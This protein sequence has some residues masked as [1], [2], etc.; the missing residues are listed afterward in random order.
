MSIISNLFWNYIATKVGSQVIYRQGINLQT[1]ETNGVTGDPA[2]IATVYTCCKVLSDNLSRMPLSV[3]LEN[4]NGRQEMKRHRL[5]YLLKHRPNNYQNAQVFWSTVEYHRNYYGNAFVR[6]YKNSNAFPTALEIIHPQL[7]KQYDFLNGELFYI[8]TNPKNNTELTVSAWDM[9]HFGNISEDG[10]ISLSPL[11]AI[12]RQTNINE[13]ATKTLD[14][15]HEN[16]AVTPAVL[17]SELP[18][19]LSGPSAGALKAS[20]ENFQEAYSGPENAGKW[21]QLPLGYKYK[22][23]AMQFADAQLIE[24][25]RFTREDISAA[26]GIPLF[27]VDGSA[28]KLDVEQLTTLFKNNTM[29]PIVARYM[30]EIN[31]KLLTRQELE[32]GF[33]V[34]YDVMSLIGMDYQTLVQ[35][36]KEQVVNGLMSPLEGALKLGNKPITGEWAKKHFMQAQYIP[37]EDYS[38]YSPLKKND[39]NLNT[40]R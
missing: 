3:F 35:G 23:I 30:A 32:S 37:L 36:I 33:S 22:S 25:L 14:K 28:E 24:S 18:S 27:M 9:L 1:T 8:V 31:S 29:G 21:V 15:F 5:T 4:D 10:I 7:I 40:A 38:N 11:V 12:E 13:R 16:N 19:T 17:E 2:R 6:V 39:P 26:Y 34:M 20:K